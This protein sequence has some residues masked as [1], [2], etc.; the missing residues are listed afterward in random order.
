M[1][2]A[3]AAVESLGS[4]EGPMSALIPAVHADGTTAR[5]LNDD[6]SLVQDLSLIHI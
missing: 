5:G 2:V 6:N 4:D 3:A 1:K